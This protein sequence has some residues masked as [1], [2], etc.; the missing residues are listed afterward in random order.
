MNKIARTFKK[1]KKNFIIYAILWL[2]AV[3]VF[4]MPFS[5][6]AVEATI[7][8][9]LNFEK[10]M[11]IS[12]AYIQTPFST[13]SKVF[14]EEYNATFI[15]IFWK[16][17]VAVIILAIIGT[18][19]NASKSEYE[20]IEHGSSDWSKNGEQYK[21]LSR[22]RGILLAEENY[23]PLDKRGNTNVLVVGRFWFW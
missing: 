16:S 20:K 13:V 5:A 18:I 14:T 3:I 7:D 15:D 8:G 2:F 11:D 1:N 9:E 19:R 4:V 17:T 22:T 10:F 21:I 12:L 23:L 6:A